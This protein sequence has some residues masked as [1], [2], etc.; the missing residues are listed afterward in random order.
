ML[1][2]KLEFSRIPVNTANIIIIIIIRIIVFLVW[3]VSGVDLADFLTSYLPEVS[4]SPS[5]K[6]FTLSKSCFVL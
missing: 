5:I 6:Y 4:V 3:M 2:A 1:K